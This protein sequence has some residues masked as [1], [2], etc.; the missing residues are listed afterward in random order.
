MEKKKREVKGISFTKKMVI[1]LVGGLIVG[2]G[3]LF[4]REHLIRSNQGAV[5]QTINQI[6][7]Q[8]IS[9]PEKGQSAIGLFYIQWPTISDCSDGLYF[10]YFSHLSYYRYAKIRTNFL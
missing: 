2:L 8:D 9:D 4:L 6:L 3:F 5:W 7:F 10:N 1:S